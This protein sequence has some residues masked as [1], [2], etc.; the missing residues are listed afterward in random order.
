MQL[1]QKPPVCGL[2]N[3]GL[4]PG[5]ARAAVHEG[6][7]FQATEG[8]APESA[9]KNPPILG[10]ASTAQWRLQGGLGEAA[11][12]R[13]SEKVLAAAHENCRTLGPR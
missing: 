2:R 9:H 11:A 10:R 7:Q 3:Q 4:E 5:A 1:K 8:K 13:P 6:E 12:G